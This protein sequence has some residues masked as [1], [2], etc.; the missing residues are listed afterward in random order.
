MSTEQ[1]KNKSNIIG[2]AVLITFGIVMLLSNLGVLSTVNLFSFIRGLA[3]YWPVVL[4]AIGLNM[5]TAGRFKWWIIGGTIALGFVLAEVDG[6][7]RTEP[8]VISYAANDLPLELHL[9]LVVDNLTLAAGR[10]QANLVQ[11]NI[12]AVA[13]VH[14]DANHQVQANRNVVRLGT[15]SRSLFSLPFGSKQLGDWRVVVNPAAPL[16]LI[17]DAGVGNSD[18]NLTDVNLEYLD[19][20]AGVGN[21]SLALPRHSTYRASLDGGVG[22]L[23]VT[24]DPTSPVIIRVDTG[25]GS[26]RMP[27]SF[28]QEGKTYYS[29]GHESGL[30]ASEIRINAG[31]GTIHVRES[32]T[33]SF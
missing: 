33:R 20:D 13:N 32:S 22:Q 27:A 15:R 30:V 16:D 3:Q 1:N 21:V 10:D 31:I 23:T 19:F 7:G 18:L 25:I 17:V 4:I 12:D 26:V 2:A 5:I 14:V 8:Q 28:R 11:A 9:D 24:V 6:G 29:P